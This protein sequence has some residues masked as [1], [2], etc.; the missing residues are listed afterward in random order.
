MI[1]IAICDDDEIYAK[2]LID[3]LTKLISQYKWLKSSIN[4][5]H[6]FSGEELLKACGVNCKTC[7]DIVFMDIEVGNEV[8]FDIAR[9]VINKIRDVGI[10]YITNY[11]TYMQDAFVGRPLG[12]IRKDKLEEDL[13]RCGDEV[14]TFISRKNRVYTFMDNMKLV[15]IKLDDVCYIEVHDHNFEIKYKNSYIRLRDTLKRVEQDLLK[16]DFVKVNR[17]T[18]VNLQYIHEIHKYECIMVDGL[19]IEISRE[20]YSEVKNEYI[21]YGIGKLYGD[22]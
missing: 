2:Y 13:N 9:Q 14:I 5:R 22:K 10:V 17:N 7:P 18:M 11:D 3:M 15:N 21:R 19:L 4:F 8:G 16:Y 20:R 1:N 12:F 6:Y